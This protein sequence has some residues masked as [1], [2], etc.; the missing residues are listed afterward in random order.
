MDVQRLQ[1]SRNKNP[2]GALQ[3]YISEDDLQYDINKYFENEDNKE[4]GCYTLSGLAGALDITTRELFEVCREESPFKKIMLRAR[5][6]IIERVEKRLVGAAQGHVGAIF[7]LKNL[8]DASYVDKQEIQQTVDQNVTINVVNYKDALQSP[9]QIEND[10]IEMN[11][12]EVQ[13]DE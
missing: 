1:L 2:H 11:T 5:Q 6:K 12:V 9:T 4:D 10:Y 3:H 13:E 7:W 8:G